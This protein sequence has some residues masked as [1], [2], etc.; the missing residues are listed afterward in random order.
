MGGMDTPRSYYLFNNGL[1][2]SGD[3]HDFSVVLASK[4]SMMSF[5]LLNAGMTL[6]SNDENYE[7]EINSISIE[8]ST[9]NN[10]WTVATSNGSGSWTASGL[11]GL[12]D[13]E[14]ASIYVRLEVNDE[15]KTDDGS[16]TGNDARF[17]VM[18]NN[19][20]TMHM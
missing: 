4:E 6:N 12:S 14:D 8:M 9:D 13:D 7:L 2:T 10:D 20:M 5:P 1:S 19:T 3:N 18:Q 16:A 11:R 17:F 15:L